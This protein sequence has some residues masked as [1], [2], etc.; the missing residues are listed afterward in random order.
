M[1]IHVAVD[2]DIFFFSISS[3]HRILKKRKNRFDLHLE[4]PD[5]F[6]RLHLLL[7]LALAVLLARSVAARAAPDPSLGEGFGKQQTI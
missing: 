6:K 2:S 7:G 4:L 5:I 1:M 3:D